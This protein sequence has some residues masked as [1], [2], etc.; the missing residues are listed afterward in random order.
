[1]TILWVD[2]ETRSHCDLPS[3]GVYNYAQDLTTEVICMAYTFNDEGV[4]TWQPGAPFPEAVRQHKGQIRAHN[5]AF[6]RLVFWYVLQVDFALEQFYCTAAQSR[7]NCAPGALGDLGRFAGAGMQ[8][9]YRGMQLIRKLSIPP[10]DPDPDGK[11]LAEMISYCMQDTRAMREVSVAQRQLTVTELD[12]Y[13]VGERINDRGVLLDKPLADAAVRYAEAERAE[14][15]ALVIDITGGEIRSVRSPKMRQWVQ[16]RVGPE[17]RKL[18]WS[19]AGA[20]RKRSIS[21]NVRASLLI[22]A[23]ENPDEVPVEVADVI[24]CADDLWASSVAKF[25]RASALADEEDSRVRGAFMFAGGGATGR[26]SSLG[27]QVH[28]FPRKS[29][30]DPEKVRSALISD[31]EIIPYFGPRVTDV[32]KQ[33]LRPSLTPVEGKSFVVADWSAIEARVNPWA[34][35]SS[36]GKDKLTLFREGQDIYKHNAVETFDVTLDKV[37]DYQRQ[38]GKVQ[39]LALGFGGGAGALTAMA[40]S[41]GLLFDD[42]EKDTMVNAWRRANHWA[43]DYWRELEHAYRDALGTPGKAFPAGRISYLFDGEHLWYELPSGRLLCYP[44]ADID[45]EG[46][47]IYAKAAWKPAADAT[48]WPR[49]RLWRGLACE[50]ITQAIAADILRDALFDLEPLG[51]VLHCHDEIVIETD[52]PD[53]VTQ[54]MHAVMNAPPEWGESLPLVAEVKTMRRYGK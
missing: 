22:L 18:M 39:E 50:N 28:N 45:K 52:D 3:A 17:A 14:I 27:L 42:D 40:R 1:M 13:H 53:G 21:K 35:N 4:Q 7:A 10:Y 33:M 37:T 12:D 38:V 32:L 46:D 47:V 19:Y 36:A 44:F 24:Q 6:E 49:A 23:E 8:K 16:D 31:Q 29:H 9:D 20:A 41:Y 54:Q 11:L 51:V 15:E 43:V 48:E 5:A 34:A 2:F 25:A 26:F 30:V